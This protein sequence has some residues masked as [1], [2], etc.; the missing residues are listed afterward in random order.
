MLC[1]VRL[2]NAPNDFL[3]YDWV[4]NP[5]DYV[6]EAP[7]VVHE[8]HMSKGAEVVFTVSGILEYIHNDYS[9][10]NTINVFSYAH[11]YYEHCRKNGLKPN[12]GLLY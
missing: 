1:A 4:A 2:E 3:R 9:L 7:G 10:K 6:F 5:S 8:L 12:E 11:L